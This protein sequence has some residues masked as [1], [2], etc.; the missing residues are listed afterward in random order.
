MIIS[1]IK[2]ASGFTARFANTRR[3]AF[4]ALLAVLALPWLFAPTAQAQ[5]AIDPTVLSGSWFDPA[6][7]GEGFEFQVL[8]N[9]GFLI[10]W[11]TYP[12][13]GDPVSAEQSFVLGVGTLNGTTATVD[14]AIRTEGPVF[15]PN[16]D[17]NDVVEKTWGSF[18]VE[19]IDEDTA[20]VD[21]D[22][23]DGQGSFEVSRLSRLATPEQ[24]GSLPAG[25]SAA[26]FDPQTSGQGWF[27][28]ILSATRALVYWF[29]YDALGNQAW[30]LG[31]GDIIGN[32]ILVREALAGTGT[33]FGA[34]FDAADVSLDPFGA[35]SIE[36]SD[37]DTGQVTWYT[38]QG[39]LRGIWPIQRLSRLQGLPCSGPDLLPAD[40]AVTLM[41][42]PTDPVLA[43]IQHPDGSRMDLFG[44]R[45]ASGLPHVLSGGLI[46]RGTDAWRLWLDDGLNGSEVRDLSGSTHVIGRNADG[47]TEVTAV[48]PLRSA[49]AARWS[50]DP[51]GNPSAT[52]S[53][54]H[55]NSPTGNDDAG[56]VPQA[57]AGTT[58][59]AGVDFC[60]GPAAGAQVDFVLGDSGS[61]TSNPAQPDFDL[62]GA[63][64]VPATRTAAGQFDASMPEA[65][66]ALQPGELAAA[67]NALGD[68]AADACSTISALGDDDLRGVCADLA[69]SGDGDSAQR[70]EAFN[71]CE[72]AY[73]EQLAFCRAWSDLDANTCAAAGSQNRE[74]DPALP[75]LYAQTRTRFV[76]GTTVPGPMPL[77]DPGSHVDFGAIDSNGTGLAGLTASPSGLNA[78]ESYD[79]ELHVP[80]LDPNQIVQLQRP[81]ESA[82][83]CSVDTDHLCRFSL[84][85]TQDMTE[86]HYQISGPGGLEFA[87][88][89]SLRSESAPPLPAT[90]LVSP[91]ADA[92]LPNRC[93]S[94][95]V[96][97]TFEWN[98]VDG[99]ASYSLEVGNDGAWSGD[100]AWLYT[101]IEPLRSS[102]PTVVFDIELDG[103]IAASQTADWTWRVWAIDA[104]GQASAPPDAER[105][106]SV[107]MCP[108]SYFGTYAG[109][110]NADG[111]I[112]IPQ[113]NNSTCT[114]STTMDLTAEAL[115]S[116]GGD[117][118]IAFQGSQ[119]TVA[120]NPDPSIPPEDCEDNSGVYPVDRFEI[121]LTVNGTQVEGLGEDDNFEVIVEGTLSE[122]GLEITFTL[123][124]LFPFVS[125]KIRSDPTL[126]PPAD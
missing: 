30:N 66:A 61:A 108:V 103:P 54:K 12:G 111:D 42:N 112:T 120:S 114:A 21:Y 62:A 56:S 18:T 59:A 107:E 93:E 115:I 1:G 38:P 90:E 70:I 50:P 71:R 76:A 48:D 80:C 125:G 45:T 91:E 84:E 74:P 72:A 23:F 110:L 15:G 124:P 52:A 65:S 122:D 3:G 126:L 101:G 13:A 109:D 63:L 116:D 49:S 5:G 4:A 98:T 53:P 92:L 78:G 10:I 77:G 118:W 17:T 57:T 51:G 27:V 9:G 8:E 119:E 67:C 58:A 19:F 6:R 35:Y 94:D 68:A 75:D 106:F 60:A 55:R 7:S 37:C 26:W 2:E 39:D 113:D 47:G 28:E 64:I 123:D 95:A 102:D 82:K 40:A 105:A 100:D 88:R 25:L 46:T 41:S 43:R 31:I 22:G 33:G 79:L 14:E 121:P 34:Q 85:T 83:S 11:Y 32:A 69:A 89:R 36:F 99:A 81:G 86:D 29:T 20:R 16:Y 96:T 24:A 44:S 117:S 104:Q 97:W 87:H 73:L